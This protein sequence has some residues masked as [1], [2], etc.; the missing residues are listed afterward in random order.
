MNKKNE[1]IKLSGNDPES[2]FIEIYND[3][4]NFEK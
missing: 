1:R 4:N 2:V 3:Y